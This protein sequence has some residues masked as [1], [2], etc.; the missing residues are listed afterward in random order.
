MTRREAEQE[1]A[2]IVRRTQVKMLVG[3]LSRPEDGH[4][5]DRAC[6]LEDVIR[7]DTQRE[8]VSS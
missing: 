6:V 1:L 7:A 2:G 4:E 5:W 8:A 3:V